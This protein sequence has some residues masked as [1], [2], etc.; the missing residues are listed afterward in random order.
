MVAHWSAWTGSAALMGLVALEA[1]S[2]SVQRFYTKGV[3]HTDRHGKALNTWDP[4]R[5]FLMIGSW[6][7]PE[8]RIYKGVDYRW[9]Q[10]VEAHYNTVWPWPMGGYTTQAQ[11][12]DAAEHDLQVI[13]M[14]RI[15]VRN[16]ESLQKAPQ[17]MGIVWQDE[18]LVNFG[19]DA[20]RQGLEQRNFAT[21]Q[22]Q[23]HTVLPDLPVLVNTSPWMVGNGRSPW[24][25][26]HRLSDISCHDNYVIWPHTRSLNLGS[27]GSEKNGIADSMQLA[28][29]VNQRTKPTWLIVGAFESM[30][31]P[32]AAFPFRY[33]TPMQLRGMVYSGVIHGATGIVY[34]AW[35][36][37]VTRFGM[38]PR[39]QP[40][41]PG[42]PSATPMQAIMGE[43]L[44]HT[45]ASINQELL[46]LKQEILT[47]TVIMDY[48][49]Q[50]EGEPITPYPV[51]TLLKHHHEEGFVLFTV[52][53]D[54]VPLK[55]RY[56]FPMMLRAARPLFENRPDLQL[57]ASGDTVELSYEPY[58]VHL[59]H[60]IP[61]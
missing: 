59:M 29:E 22:K 10:L 57:P 35:D 61:H 12:E 60:L 16:L 27:Y 56:R 11:L 55:A 30:D 28:L 40:D 32:Q 33:P 9:H 48:A 21:Y 2:P 37:N 26:W 46:S 43:T 31:S 14:R 58:E 36:S 6:G 20:A 53:M 5:S 45:A 47:P 1:A 18:P 25:Q 17:L 44:W 54:S 41:I 51:R 49:V 24:I 4:D 38:A 42:R 19:T 50:I 15:D 39:R 3:P 34:Y 23:I 7:V 13:L 8:S 52:N